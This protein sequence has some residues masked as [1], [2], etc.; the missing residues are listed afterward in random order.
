MEN[1]RLEQLA[2]ATLECERLIDAAT[3]AEAKA[4]QAQTLAVSLYSQVTAA[5]FEV[6]QASDVVAHKIEQTQTTFSTMKILSEYGATTDADSL[7]LKGCQ[8]Q[9]ESKQALEVYLQKA[10]QLTK[11]SL[12]YEEARTNVNILTAE[13]DRLMQLAHL[14]MAKAASLTQS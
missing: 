4:S 7:Y 9:E 10:D 5:M 6:A 12:S 3:I 14:A 13:R 8:Q 11:L 2:N 1:F